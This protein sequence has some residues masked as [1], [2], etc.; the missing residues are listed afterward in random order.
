MKRFTY[1]PLFVA[2]WPL[3]VVGCL[4]NPNSPP[5]AQ[6]KVDA[7][8]MR[9][10]PAAVNWDA[11]PGPDG[12]QGVVIL[13]SLGESAS[14]VRAVPVSGTLELL[15][16]KGRVTASTAGEVKPA[17]TWTF[18]G[19]QLL[20]MLEHG[21][22]GWEYVLRLKWGDKPPCMGAVTLV[23]RYRQPDGRWLYSAPNCSITISK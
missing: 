4:R 11:K 6:A 13:Y 16:F 17:Y 5:P 8:E 1:L 2:L 14:A 9:V 22:V 7:I 20:P 18:T 21:I 23:A 19:E 3:S 10:M 15:M 12:L